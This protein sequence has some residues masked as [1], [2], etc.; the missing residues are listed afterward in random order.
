MT[1]RRAKALILFL[2]AATSAQADEIQHTLRTGL[3]FGTQEPWVVEPLSVPTFPS[4]MGELTEVRVEMGSDVAAVH[5]VENL[6][7]V[8]SMAFLQSV[9]EWGVG[10]PDEERFVSDLAGPGDAAYLDSYDGCID[11]RG[12]SGFSRDWAVRNGVSAVTA[13]DPRWIDEGSGAR[14]P[15]DLTCAS[16]LE[17]S[18]DHGVGDMKGAIDLG[19]TVTY[20]FSPPPMSERP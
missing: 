5:G 12:T 10:F 7:A 17:T 1:A 19:I 2:V 18:I 11:F 3:H 4:E 13:P 6:S 16:M 15:L 20:V 9:V 8:P 14:V